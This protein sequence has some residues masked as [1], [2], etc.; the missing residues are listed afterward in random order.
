MIVEMYNLCLLSEN[1]DCRTK[2]FVHKTNAN[3]MA[4]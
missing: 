2:I 4:L 3:I 1:E